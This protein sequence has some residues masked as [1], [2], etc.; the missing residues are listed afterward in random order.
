MLAT[1]NDKQNDPHDAIDISPDVVLASRTD[2]TPPAL[3]PEITNRLEPKIGLASNGTTV[4]PSVDKAVSAAL[5][6]D[7]GLG[8]F[9]NARKRSSISK[10]LRRA[11]FSVLFATGIAAAAVTWQARGDTIKTMVTAWIPTLALTASSSQPPQPVA[12]DAVAPAPQAEAQPAVPVH[13][14]DAVATTT[15]AISP[16]VAQSLQSMTHDLAALGQRIEELKAN[17]AELKAGQEQMARELAKATAAKP[18]ETR[19]TDPHARTADPHARTST[20]PPHPPATPVHKP[21]PV[22]TPAYAPTS[23]PAPVVPPPQPRTVVVPPPP[24]SA[25]TAQTPAPA[26]Q[27]RADDG[28]PVVRP[29]M[30]MN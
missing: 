29:P 22:Q 11:L 3:T 19:T 1:P 5:Q 6:A 9:R 28:G 8:D 26:V 15:N 12:E 27:T 10:W 18:A 13:Q 21:K 7:L 16:D 24:V 23:A 2:R 30:P 4:A 14:Q 20:L 25:P 17:I